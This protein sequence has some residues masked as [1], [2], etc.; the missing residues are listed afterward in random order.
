[1]NGIDICLGRN[2]A[3]D[4]SN[5]LTAIPELSYDEQNVEKIV[6]GSLPDKVHIF[7]FAENKVFSGASFCHCKK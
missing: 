2:K 1:V 7:Y 4:K 3:N 6:K 5:E